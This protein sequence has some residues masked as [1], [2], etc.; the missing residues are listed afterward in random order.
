LALP[1]GTR[2]GSYEI[3]AL[4]GVGGMGEVYRARDMKLGRDVALKI[5][6]GPLANHPDRVTRFEREARMLASF[7]H[8][9]IGAIYGLEDADGVRALILELV[10]GET[11]AERLARRPVLLA[12]ALAI[13]RQLADALD[14]AHEK[15]IVH[16]DL[17][18]ANIKITPDGVVKVLDF[19]LAKAAAGDASPDMTQAATVSVG[20]TLQGTIVGTVAYMSPEQAR[21]QAVDKRTDIWAFGCVLFEMLTGRPLFGKA[22]LSDTLVAV[23][24]REPEWSALPAETPES[25]V[26]VLRRCLEKDPLR[27]LRDIG[28]ARAELEVTPGPFIAGDRTTGRRSSRLP[29]GVAA[30]ASL[31]AAVVA[32]SAWRQANRGEGAAVAPAFSRI[33]PITAGPAREF[34]PVLSPDGKWV[35]YVSDT[36]GAPNVWVKFLAGGDAVNLTSAA[37]LDVSAS[38][39]INGLEISP[40]GSRIA[41]Q[42][43]TR[44][45]SAAFATWEIP[46]PLP[47]APRQLLDPGFLAM[48]WSPDGTRMTFIRAGATAGDVI[49][50]ADGDGA[51]AREIVPGSGGAH[52]H[53][54]SWAR[55]GRIY[56]MRPVMAG[57]N[58]AQTEIYRVDPDG[59]EPEPVITTLRR[60]MFPL[61]LADGSLIYSANPSGVELGLWWR[62]PDGTTS[63]RLTF[64]LGDYLEPRTALDGRLLVATRY[65]NRQSLVRIEAS[66]PRLGTTTPLTDGHGGDL[67]PTIARA[68]G[69]MVFS[70][71]RVGNRHLWTADPD[72]T[73][74]RPLTSGA[75][76]DDR[77]S[78]SPDGQTAAFVSDR[79]GQSGI[80][81]IAAAG[82]TPR[83]LVDALPVSSLSWSRDGASIVY[84]ASAGVGPG[85]WS[86]SIADG[87]VKR[88][89]TA[90]AA[91]EPVW[92][93]TTDLVAYLEPATTGPSFTG[94]AF[95]TP[96][97]TP[98]TLLAEQAPN[99][100]AGVPNGLLAWSP[101]GRRLAVAAQNTNLP[102]M[103]WLAEPGGAV[104]FRKLVE[105]PIGARI[106]GMTWSQDGAAVIVGQYDAIG[107]IVLLDQQP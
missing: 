86:V 31:V 52:M 11:L 82:G 40:D 57:A 21:G 19:G 58:L 38:S 43:K 64:G 80:W 6:P 5:L 61:P 29:W 44:G 101:D 50:V 55:D 25:V 13:A 48:R 27:R 91:G 96:D 92:S 90:G 73:N 72:G 16:R 23:L 103:V 59:G 74:A 106:R 83:K 22:T 10:E 28:D 81:L 68:G 54:L 41:V 12:D 26:R 89:P 35:A 9:H 7:N 39:Q 67:D 63:R 20:G 56:Y 75:A 8:R 49:L 79:G 65:E 18:P 4:I 36:G 104:P 2:L 107:D 37:G 85:L 47:G 98:Q 84:A 32:T 87:Q 45:S 69:R 102:T 71:A 105:L 76:Q 94:V 62:P 97:G 30:A 42:A 88:L 60:A 24:E 3:A 51:N 33:V 34:G 15:G 53:W 99:I 70:S 46:A 14:A 93:P 1:A 95:V 78:L 17:K 100:S 77:P 66:G